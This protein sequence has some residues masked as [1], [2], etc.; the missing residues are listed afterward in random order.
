MEQP[1]HA[2]PKSTI[3]GTYIGLL[4]LSALM[5]AI[6]RVP[7]DRIAIDWIDLHA[8]KTTVIM[9][10]AL[11][12]GSIIALFLMG[13]RYDHKLLNATIFLSN[14][15]FL[16]IFVLFTWADTS[17]RGEVDPSFTKAI[18][19]VSPIKAETEA[20]EATAP[21]LTAPAHTA[22]PETAPAAAH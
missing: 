15:V 16:L 1:G 4:V 3:V 19:F 11:M 21:A 13:L 12:M 7:V 20:A 6:A 5:I 8:V 22:P 9:L 10:T 2:I 14:F 17:F 18:N